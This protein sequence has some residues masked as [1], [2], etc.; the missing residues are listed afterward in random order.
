MKK[1]FL[2]LAL[3]VVM[4]VSAVLLTACGSDDKLSGKYVYEIYGMEITMSFDGDKVTMDVLGESEEGTYKLKGDK[5]DITI[6]GDTKTADISS[7]H[8][9]IT[10]ELE[11]ME[12]EFTK[13]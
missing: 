6:D 10:L 1:R 9:T 5:V 8:K 4:I 12:M 11:G 3:A 7:D 2:S 13:K